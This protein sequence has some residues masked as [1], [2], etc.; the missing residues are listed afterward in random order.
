MAAEH[1]SGNQHHAPEPPHSQEFE[2]APRRNMPGDRGQAFRPCVFGHQHRRTSRG[3]EQRRM[4]HDNRGESPGAHY[5]PTDQCARDEGPEPVPR[6]QPYSNLVAPS[7]GAAAASARASA[8]VVIGASA[9]AW[10]TLIINSAQ[11]PAAG[12]RPRATSAASAV[13]TARTARSACVRSASRPH[14]GPE[15]SRIAVPVAN[16]SPSCSGTS[17]RASKNAG[18]NGDE[19][20][21]AAYISAY[22]AMKRRSALIG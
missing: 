7:R 12:N 10:S 22:R 16:R 19:T 2:H 9:A 21:N 1:E 13:Q 3:G 14:N 5:L 8:S 18:I 11:K 6:A 15:M 17:P 4:R 20:P